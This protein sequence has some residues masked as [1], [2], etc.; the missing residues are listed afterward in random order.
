MKNWKFQNNNFT[1]G[2]PSKRYIIKHARVSVCVCGC[3]VGFACL[4]FEGAP[5]FFEKSD[6]DVGVIQKITKLRAF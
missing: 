4:K 1:I 2:L 5:K 6:C 3:A